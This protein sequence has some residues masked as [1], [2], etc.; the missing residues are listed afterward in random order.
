MDR[1][2]LVKTHNYIIRKLRQTEKCKLADMPASLDVSLIGVSLFCQALVHYKSPSLVEWNWVN[3]WAWIFWVGCLGCCR[4]HCFLSDLSFNC[5]IH[6]LTGPVV[7]LTSDTCSM[8][9]LLP[10][11]S[12]RATH[13]LF[14]PASLTHL[15]LQMPA[16]IF[17]GCK[18]QVHSV[19]ALIQI[20]S[21]CLD[22]PG[23]QMCCD[24]SSFY[25]TQES[26]L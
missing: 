7:V 18:S 25:P 24:F 12:S 6:A 10:R 22:G 17:T 8:F 3:R 21:C 9:P 19:L 14:N 23:Q 16:N 11:P 15:W 1:W 20:R 26:S 5:D 4:P 2:G 13:F